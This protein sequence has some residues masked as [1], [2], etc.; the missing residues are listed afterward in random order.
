MVNKYGPNAGVDR[1]VRRQR[2]HFAY[3]PGFYPPD[4]ATG[5][6]DRLPE[7]TGPDSFTVR[8]RAKDGATRNVTVNITVVAPPRTCDPKFVADTRTMFNDPSGNEAQQYA[9]AP[10]P[11][12]D[13]RLHADAR[14]RTGRGRSSG[15][16]S[17]P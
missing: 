13:D 7:Y 9:D 17:T 11:H 4:P 6:R 2:A 14:T 12:Q 8:V 3:T 5:K 10:L 15:S 16:A 1:L